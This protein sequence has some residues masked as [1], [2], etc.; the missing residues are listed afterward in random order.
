[1]SP[2]PHGIGPPQSQ[3]GRNHVANP[4]CW[5]D[6]PIEHQ[7]PIAYDSLKS[8]NGLTDLIPPQAVFTR[9][10][11]R[12]GAFLGYVLGGLPAA[13][14]WFTFPLHFLCN[15][16][17]PES[18]FAAGIGVGP[19][20]NVEWLSLVIRAGVKALWVR[21]T[22]NNM[23][24]GSYGDEAATILNGALAR[25]NAGEEI[26]VAGIHADRLP[27]PLPNPLFADQIDEDSERFRPQPMKYDAPDT[28]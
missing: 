8:F 27:A 10:H 7:Y 6:P 18:F 2:G 21:A 1:M 12:G 3:P 20:G 23:H 13:G 4:H 14:S 25:W 22:T 5:A 28:V 9:T 26:V 15:E 11:A 24:G 16:S 19:Q 17:V